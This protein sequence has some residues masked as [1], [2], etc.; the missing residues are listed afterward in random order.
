MF[1]AGN[2]LSAI[3]LGTITW[4]DFRT[5]LIS[6]WLLPALAVVLLLGESD[7][8]DSST[9]IHNTSVNIVLLLLLFIFLMAWFSIRQKRLTFIIDQQI[10]L[11]DLLFLVAVAPVCAPLNFCLFFSASCAVTLVFGVIRA[12]I[13]KPLTSFP[14]AG[15]MAILLLCYETSRA[16][17]PAA[18]ALSSDRWL[19]NLITPTL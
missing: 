5:R 3:L 10:G 11:G 8:V 9:V 19:T 16:I 6:A 4:Q 13:R 14:L 12:L 7:L 18:F 17:S 15:V 2:I 1:I